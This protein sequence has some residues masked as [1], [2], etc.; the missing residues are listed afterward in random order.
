MVQISADIPP[1]LRAAL[2]EKA[3]RTSGGVSSIITAA[4]AHYL[5]KPI[6][7]GFSSLNVWR[8]RGR[9]LRSRGQR[10]DAPGTR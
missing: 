3:A 10:P 7:Y 1:S 9:R 6:H 4:L 8:S 2:E 5:E